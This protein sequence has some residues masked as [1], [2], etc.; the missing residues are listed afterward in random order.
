VPLLVEIAR[1]EPEE[2][3]HMTHVDRWLLAALLLALASPAHA[4]R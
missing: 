2:E 3:G 1:E 4:D